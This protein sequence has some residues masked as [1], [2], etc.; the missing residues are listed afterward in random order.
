MQT[1]WKLAC[2]DGAMRVL[3]TVAL[4][5]CLCAARAPS[6]SLASAGSGALQLHPSGASIEKPL[7]LIEMHRNVDRLAVLDRQGDSQAIALLSQ[8]VFERVGIPPEVAGAFHLT[9]RLAQA[10][11]DYRSGVLRPVHEA[12]IVLACNNLIKA[13]GVADWAKTNPSELRQMRMEFMAGYP[14]LLGSHAPAGPDGRFEALSADI[15]PV[16]AVF[17]GT[18]LLYQKLYRPEFQLTAEEKSS[19]GVSSVPEAT[20][21]ARTLELYSTLHLKTDRVGVFE[22]SRAADGFFDDLRIA[23][24]LRPEFE[25]MPPVVTAGEVKGGLQ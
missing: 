23:G 4:F 5:G 20:L 25:A 11:T 3:C 9:A 7:T 14:Q 13:V 10:E 17:L 12:D 16:E 2:P 1:P 22:L 21:H 15:S 19:G 6:Q 24:S 18:S 8:T